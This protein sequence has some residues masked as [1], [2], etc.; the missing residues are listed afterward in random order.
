VRHLAL[1]DIHG[2]YKALVTLAGFVPFG[3]NDVLVTL[4]DY[5]DR[6]PNSCAVV[7]WLMHYKANHEL[8]ALRGNHEVMML[9]ARESDS[10]LKEWLRNGGN[11][12]LASYS[13]FE[14]Q[15]HLVDVPDEHWRFIEET[16][17]WH[18][19]ETHFFVHANAYPNCPLDEQPDLMLYWEQFRDP[20]PHESG[21]TMVCGHTP[22]KS[23][24]PKYIG[25]AVCIDTDACRGG[26][27]TCLDVSERVYWQANERGETRQV[28]L[29]LAT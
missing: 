5:V 22:Q 24:R 18:E 29:H 28:L 13:P 23:G 17:P 3:A 16:L 20:P 25:H 8:I 10:A 27:L 15:G 21:K 2:C 14:D 11:A 6:G 19:M 26:W 12:A 9:A 7:D 1:G 4:G